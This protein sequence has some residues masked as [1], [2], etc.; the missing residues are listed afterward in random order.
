MIPVLTAS[1]SDTQRIK[2]TLNIG[3]PV[4][5]QLKADT[6]E[7]EGD[8]DY[9]IKFLWRLGLLCAWD[10]HHGISKKKFNFIGCS[11]VYVQ[12]CGNQ[13]ILLPCGECY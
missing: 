5:V 4:T 8:F 10:P 1:P 7:W 11:C 12:T 13:T 3:N 9:L 6:N 2:D